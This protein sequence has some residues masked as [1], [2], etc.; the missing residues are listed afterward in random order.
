MTP[1][2]TTIVEPEN[3]ILY[4]IYKMGG[5]P[6]KEFAEELG[7]PQQRIYEVLKGKAP[8]KNMLKKLGLRV[9]YQIVREDDV[10]KPEKPAK[11]KKQAKEPHP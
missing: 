2:P 9:V 10:V 1:M 6:V 4:I 8:S 11:R 7:F 5:K 3:L